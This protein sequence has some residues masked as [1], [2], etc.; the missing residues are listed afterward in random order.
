MQVL[1]FSQLN[2]LIKSSESPK[3]FH[4][5]KKVSKIEISLHNFSYNT[6]LKASVF[7]KHILQLKKNRISQRS[8]LKMV[9]SI[10]FFKNLEILG[11]TRQIVKE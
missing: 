6:Q 3:R 2:I 5:F 7:K 10:E 11:S 9:L 1:K 4:N 8:D